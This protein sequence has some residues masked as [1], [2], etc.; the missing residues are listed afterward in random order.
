MVR[1]L[2]VCAVTGALAFGTQTQSS[3][4]PDQELAEKVRDLMKS[5]A[6]HKG[7]PEADWQTIYLNL[8]P[9]RRAVFD[10]AVRHLFFQPV[11]NGV[12]IGKRLI[13]YVE[14]VHGIW[15]VRLNEGDGKKQFRLSIVWNP[16]VIKYLQ[17]VHDTGGN[18][19][20]SDLGHVLMPGA[21]ETP[22]S[23]PVKVDV[24]GPGGVV[25]YRE[26]STA[27]R[28][29]ASFL[30]ENPSIGEVDVD[31]DKTPCLYP[32]SCHCQPSN[33]DVGSFASNNTDHHLK[34]HNT[35]TA[36]FSP[37]APAWSDTAYHCKGKYQ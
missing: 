19:S 9:D 36:R 24:R 7:K 22:S 26:S 25:T 35:A 12:P 28:L 5:Y 29:Q 20:R 17:V 21:D 1:L 32:G 4:T 3:L 30:T 34:L 13:D 11:S 27:Q 31:Y 16:L 15:G 8:S 10:A 23:Q 2:L 6:K 33:S 18:I 14:A 37:L